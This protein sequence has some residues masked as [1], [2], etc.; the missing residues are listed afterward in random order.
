MYSFESRVR[1][2]ECD[3]DE[4]LSVL[5]M[6]DYLQD[7]STFHSNDVGQ[8]IDVLKK[9]HLAWFISNWQIEIDC[10]PRF[11]DR[12]VVS[13][14][15]HGFTKVFG[16]RNFAIRDLDG[17]DFVRADSLWFLF[18]SELGRPVRITDDLSA[19]YLPCDQQLAMS[20]IERRIAVEGAGRT[21]R[22][23]TVNEQHLDSNHHVNNAQYVQMALDAIERK[24]VIGQ[25]SVQYKRA[26]T[27][28]DTIV[29]CVHD[30]AD[31]LVIDLA[32][33]S[34]DSFAIVKLV[35]QAD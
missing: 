34:G 29:P 3:E 27:L 17:H 23:I 11:S 9:E 1:Y 20:P 8:G 4:T 28:G 22:I 2:S 6:I 15:A 14:W 12:I 33:E 5:G 26:A 7:C 16:E 19:P 32:D 10:L 30:A 21:G 31:G 25:L 35:A 13:T 24:R 18:D